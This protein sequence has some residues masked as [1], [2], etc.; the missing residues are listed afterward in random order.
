MRT[1]ILD[2][3]AEEARKFFLRAE[4][5]STIELPEYFQFQPIL[6][7]VDKGIGRKKWKE[8]KS[9]VNPKSIENVNFHFIKNK[10]GR[11][12]WRPM[13]IIHP[14]MYVSLVNLIT[15]SEHWTELQDRFRYI[16]EHASSIECLSIPLYKEDKVNKS[17]VVLN[18]WESIELQT[19]ELSLEF[20]YMLNTD[21]VNCYGSVYTHTI[22]WALYGKDAVKQNLNVYEKRLG[23]LIDSHIQAMSYQQTNGIPQGSVLM[24]FI[25]EIILAYADLLLFNRLEKKI[26]CN[27]YHILRYRDDYRIFSKS[28]DILEIIAKE[29]SA[30]LASLNFKLNAQK[31]FISDTLITDSVKSDKLF[32]LKSKHG[33][34]TLQK[35]L[36]LIHMLAN[37]YPNSGSL[38][39]ALADFYSRI[40]R[41]KS[42]N[43]EKEHIKALIGILIDIAYRNPRTYPCAISILGCLLSNISDARD[44]LRVIE[45]IK[46]KFSI[47]SDAELLNVWLQRICIKANPEVEF[48]GILCK[49]VITPS[50]NLWNSDWLHSKY[51]SIVNN[52]DFINRQ[53]LNDIPALVPIDV[54]NAFAK[55]L[56]K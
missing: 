46:N 34:K 5:Y 49:N 14:V 47:I 40:R 45:L 17:Y 54:I 39:R 38:D 15:E 53:C 24:D 21:I 43:E 20:S 23:G 52:S 18:W 55:D 4:S 33:S 28:K 44:V 37:E 48:S 2:I 9:D 7:A 30:V 19:Q 31:T 32:W 51:Q 16:H 22:P 12:A 41:L 10:D 27:D 8:L 29:L 1:S 6:D 36:L 26:T 56:Y 11:Y 13:Q 3:S 50:Q 42:I 25:A 35:H